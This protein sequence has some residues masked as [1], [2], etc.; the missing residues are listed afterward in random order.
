LTLLDRVLDWLRELDNQ[1][2]QRA[3][4][5][6][7]RALGVPDSLTLPNYMLNWDEI[8]QMKAHKIE[9]GAHTVSHPVLAQTSGAQLQEEIG[10]SK[11]TIE[12][13]LKTEVRHFAYPFGRESHYGG[14]AKD[15]VQQCG[16]KTAVTTEF[17]FN[18]PG[19]DL[20]A[21]K[22][23][24]PWGHDLSSFILQLDWYRFA[25]VR[26]SPKQVEL[27]ASRPAAAEALRNRV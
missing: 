14:E 27:K 11:T 17:G 15:C 25:G 24:T 12:Q 8:K 10:D 19:D 5:A 23:F 3:L 1:E 2:R 6:I 26:P 7:F 9:F 20:F 16:F 18:A 21:L 22:R 4:P 13:K